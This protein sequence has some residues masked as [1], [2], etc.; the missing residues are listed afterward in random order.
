VDAHLVVGELGDAAHVTLVSAEGLAEE[1]INDCQAR[2]QVVHAPAQSDDVGIV[3]LASQPGG[4]DRP[5]Q[6]CAYPVNLVGGDLL[7]VAAPPEN[8]AEASGVGHHG[9]ST[10]QA[11]SGIVVIWVVGV[12]S[13]VDDVVPLLPQMLD[14]GALE[15]EAGV[16]GGDMDAHRQ[17]CASREQRFAPGAH[18][19]R[20][21]ANGAEPG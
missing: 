7:P 6:G 18:E 9:L 16:V 10:G 2:S 1:G 11:E 12:G 15:L 8:N 5:G 13:V 17:D 4:L 14:H 19:R 20:Q 21:D 3:V